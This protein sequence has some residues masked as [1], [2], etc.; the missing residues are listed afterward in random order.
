MTG[1]AAGGD[2][3][4]DVNLKNTDGSGGSINSSGE[5]DNISNDGGGH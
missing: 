3:R 5:G 4:N 1:S 2:I